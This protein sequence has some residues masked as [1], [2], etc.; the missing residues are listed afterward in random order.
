MYQFKCQH[1][2]HPK[3]LNDFFAFYVFYAHKTHPH[4][5]FAFFPVFTENNQ[6]ILEYGINKAKKECTHHGST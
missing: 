1:T 2:N 5:D 3:L 6:H 4:T